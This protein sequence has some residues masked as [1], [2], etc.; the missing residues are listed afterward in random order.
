MASGEG[1]FDRSGARCSEERLGRWSDAVRALRRQRGVVAAGPPHPQRTHC[2]EAD[3]TLR[4]VAAGQTEAAAVSDL[5][6][7]SQ[8][9]ASRSAVAAASPSAQ[10]AAG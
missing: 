4:A 7:A 1:G 10:V 5:L 6:F 2:V 9:G 3:W 8:A